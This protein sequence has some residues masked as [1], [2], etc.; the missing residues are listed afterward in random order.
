MLVT[1]V[2]GD[3]TGDQVI[4]INA[5]GSATVAVADGHGGWET[6]ATGHVDSNGNLVI[7]Q[8]TGGTGGHGTTGG[9]TG[10]TDHTTSDHTGG[11]G[12]SPGG[13]ITVEVNGQTADVGP[14]TIDSDGNGSP[15]TAVVQGQDGSTMFVTD[16]NG[17]GTGD[18]VIQVGQDGSATVAVAD[19]HG[20][21]ETVATGH[22][23]SNGTL[24]I[25][26]QA[27]AQTQG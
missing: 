23:D 12:T 6:V 11:T 4:E 26:Q 17:D 27:Q 18:Q 21:W 5:D 1:D 19:G 22:V 24:V 16:V 14:A 7:D 15:D 3:G 25:D 8:Q 10:T 9:T 13:D 20:G 2:N